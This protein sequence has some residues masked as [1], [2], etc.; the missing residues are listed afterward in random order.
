MSSDNVRVVRPEPYWLVVLA[1]VGGDQL[2]KVLVSGLGSPLVVGP[3]SLSR[4]INDVG[5]FGL[6]LSNGTL[7]LIGV[8][9]VIALLA[10]LL[11][12]I[13]RQPARLGLWLILGGALSNLID[14]ATAGGVVDVIAVENIARFNLADVMIVLGLLSL[15]RSVWWRE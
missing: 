9:L 1:L 7:V 4:T 10:V 6:A 11:S 8:G 13:D 5:I 14:R 12:G 2:V 3:V 15:V